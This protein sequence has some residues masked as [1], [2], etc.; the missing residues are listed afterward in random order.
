MQRLRISRRRRQRTLRSGRCA[1]DSCGGCRAA[2]G[3]GWRTCAAAAV[4]RAP[5]A[6]VDGVATAAAAGVAA[7]AGGRCSAARRRPAT[8]AATVTGADAAASRAGAGARP[9]AAC[10][11]A[12]PVQR[13]RL[14]VCPRLWLG[15]SGATGVPCCPRGCWPRCRH[16]PCRRHQPAGKPGQQ[17]GR[18]KRPLHPATPAAGTGS[19]Q[20][21]RP[22]TVARPF[23]LLSK[24]NNMSELC[25][26]GAYG[27]GADAAGAPR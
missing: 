4:P 23:P 12:Q 15:A 2:S 7:A 27:K 5:G 13:R 11:A 8:A 26:Q 22:W 6:A 16:M 1:A 17:Q 18:R 10:A 21:P 9:C 19:G 25:E 14:C 3:S 20:W 24:I